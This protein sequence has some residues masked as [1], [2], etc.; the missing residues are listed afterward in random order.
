MSIS[1]VYIRKEFD[2]C[3]S[4]PETDGRNIQIPAAP[5]GVVRLRPPL[6]SEDAERILSEDSSFAWKALV[7]FAYSHKKFLLSLPI[8]GAMILSFNKRLLKKKL[9]EAEKKQ[10][11]VIDLSDCISWYTDDC[12]IECYRRLLGREPD[13]EGLE[14]ARRQARQGAGNDVIAYM[15]ASSEEFNDRAEVANLREYRRAYK[16]FARKQRVLRIPVL[17]RLIRLLILPGQL[18]RLYERLERSELQ[19]NARMDQLAQMTLQGNAEAALI[20]E[21]MADVLQRTNAQADALSAKLDVQTEIGSRM[22]AELKSQATLGNSLLKKLDAQAALGS[23]LS[24]KLDAQAALGNNLSAK[25]DAQAALGNNLSAKLDAQ[26]ALGSN[27]SAKLDAQA[28]LDSTLS[29]K[30]DV[31]SGILYALSQ[32]ADGQAS[33]SSSVSEKLDNLPMQVQQIAVSSHTAITSVPGGVTG[34]LTEGFILGVP[35]EEWNLAMYLSQGGHF[36]YA[37]EKFFKGLLREGMAVLDLGAN[38]GI[39]TLHALKAGCHVFSYEPTP[40]ICE[41]LRQNVKVNAFAETGRST[42]FQSAVSNVC[43][44][45]IFYERAGTCGQ[46]NSI[47]GEEG[48]PSYSVQMVTLDS[49]REML[50]KID[51]I[52]MDIEGAEYNALL[53]MRELLAENPGVQIMM[54]YAPAHIRRAGHRPEELLELIKEYGFTIKLIDE[55]TGKVRAVDDSELKRLNDSETVNLY[56]KRGCA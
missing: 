44:E 38:L 23:N 40:R 36:E 39:Y 34:V 10:T 22:S 19:L 28:A 55:T 6:T 33:I 21:R 35:S 29:E 52:K 3:T 43:K 27:L 1:R 46:C 16:R 30:M 45:S 41:I 50:G 9:R 56:L 14:N 18:M 5:A 15:I 47:Y 17:G 20:K 8:L 42:V 7:R 24:A 25:L 48:D 4:V 13:P 49:Q 2:R 54:E 32:K 26:A 37:C 11:G 31:H 53:G 12:I 51:V